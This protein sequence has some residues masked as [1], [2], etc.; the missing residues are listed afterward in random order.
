MNK[1][2]LHT[3]L[4]LLVV[5]SIGTALVTDLINSWLHLILTT[6]TLEWLLTRQTLQVLRL[7]VQVQHMVPVGDTAI[8]IDTITE[9]TER[10]RLNNGDM[11]FGWKG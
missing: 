4:L 8:A 5:N 9:Q 7:Q 1:T 3:E 2:I 6:I 11:I 10:N